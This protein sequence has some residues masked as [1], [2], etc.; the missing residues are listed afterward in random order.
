MR[1]NDDGIFEIL[2]VVGD[3]YVLKTLNENFEITGDDKDGY[4]MNSDPD[5]IK[6]V[7]NHV[8]CVKDNEVI[9]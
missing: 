4:F 3:N 8:I 2:L 1:Y 5:N 6:R 7:T 9:W